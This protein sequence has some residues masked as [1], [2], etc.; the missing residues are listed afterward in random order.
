M[1]PAGLPVTRGR[2]K[3]TAI[4]IAPKI[5]ILSVSPIRE[6]HDLLGRILDPE[7]WVIHAVF[8][9]RSAKRLLRTEQVSVVICER[10]LPDGGWADLLSETISSPKPPPLIVASRLAD[11]CLWAEALN[12]GAYDVL[13][14]PFELVE[15]TRALDL[16]WNRWKHGQEPVKSM[17]ASA[18]GE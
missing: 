1:S 13:P 18:T 12:A 17:G 4:N 7:R 14:K 15:V 9:V 2:R 11:E 8:T 5:R 3:L 16:A 10:H 6:D